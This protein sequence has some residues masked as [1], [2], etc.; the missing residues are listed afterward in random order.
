[1]DELLARIS[2]K[3]GEGLRGGLDVAISIAATSA[4]NGPALEQE[5]PP[6]HPS[7]EHHN[8]HPPA[9][10]H[11]RGSSSAQGVV[12]G[13]RISWRRPPK[14]RGVISQARKNVPRKEEDRVKLE[15]AHFRPPAEAGQAGDGRQ[16]ETA[17]SFSPLYRRGAGW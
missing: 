7:K 9:G 5:S 1:M 4:G 15:E 13:S 14:S 12:H 8:H 3:S 16:A 6:G 11:S 2:G 10:R 17:A